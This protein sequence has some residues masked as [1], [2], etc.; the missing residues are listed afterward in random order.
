MDESS[1]KYSCW[2]KGKPGKSNVIYKNGQRKENQEKL[3]A[4]AAYCTVQVF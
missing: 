4:K 2:W 1:L 3:G